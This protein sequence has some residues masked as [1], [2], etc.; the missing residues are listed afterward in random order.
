MP[1]SERQLCMNIFLAIIEIDSNI[2]TLPGLQCAASKWLRQDFLCV[3]TLLRSIFVDASFSL[4][5]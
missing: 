2:A 3:M 5:K 4:N 1:F